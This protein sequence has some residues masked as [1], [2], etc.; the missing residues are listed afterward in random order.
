M[1]AG[2]HYVLMAWYLVGPVVGLAVAVVWARRSR[3]LSPLMS[4]ILTLISAAVIATTLVMIYATTVEGR[5]QLGQLIR[6]IYF[7]AGMLLL[8]KAFDYGLRG[9]VKWWVGRPATTDLNTQRRIRR[10]WIAVPLR[11]VLLVSIGLPYVMAAVMTYRPKVVP[12]AEPSRPFE[13]IHFEASDGT[14]LTGWWIATS[15]PPSEADGRW[16]KETLLICHGLA[17]N[18]QNHLLLGEFALPHGYNLF[19]FDFRAHG[20]SGGQFTTFG[21]RERF[22]VLGA[23]RWLWE[24]R[25]EQAER[26]HGVGA[27]MGAAALIA[28]AADASPEG[29]AIDSVV[30]LGTFADLGRL[31]TDVSQNYFIR[32][33]DWLVRYVA[34]PMAA[35]QTNAD[36]TG[37]SPA[38]Q[39]QRIWPR[40][41]LIVHG[42]RDEI[43][44]F[45]QAE[46][47]YD[48]AAQPKH[49]LWVERAGHND[50]LESDVVH[51]RILDFLKTAEPVP[52]VEHL[53][54][55]SGLQ[56]GQYCD[57]LYRSLLVPH[58]ML[59]GE[60][61]RFAFMFCLILVSRYGTIDA[62]P[63][64]S[65]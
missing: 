57:I 51:S 43:I 38:E 44:P 40:P 61:L 41:I 55:Q 50:V 31:A 6:A 54:D 18:K 34:V 52:V 49:S 60:S 29:Q 2:F 56:L 15:S 24:N 36:L 62:S 25:P 42:L 17:A 5:W 1:R 63:S 28:A 12:L 64:L 4:Y 21:D 48:A 58:N 14:P 9:L 20:E 11:I 45:T 13:V 27:S 19:I 3:Q 7:A 23:V 39:V 16:G 53:P 46:A 26:I 10:L 30:V 47:L 37:F 65:A 22:D 32:P 35:A 8:I 59:R 33:L